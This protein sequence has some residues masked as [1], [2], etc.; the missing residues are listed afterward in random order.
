[1]NVGSLRIG[2]LFGNPV[3]VG[4]RIEHYTLSLRMCYRFRL[5]GVLLFVGLV[6][7]FDVI[8]CMFRRV[9]FNYPGVR[10]H[11]FMFDYVIS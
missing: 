1:M 2:L 4:Y 9:R 11:F 7:V 6:L 8:V 3:S 10:L 5:F